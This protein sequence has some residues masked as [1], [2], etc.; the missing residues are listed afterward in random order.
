[1]MTWLECQEKMQWH[2][3]FINTKQQ[4]PLQHT[5]TWRIIGL[6]CTRA[7]SVKMAHHPLAKVVS[8][9]NLK[10]QY[11]APNFQDALANFVTRLNYPEA[12]G[13]TLRLRAMD[14]LIPF[15][16]VPVFHVVKFTETNE[17]EIIDSVHARPEQ[18][19]KHGQIIPSHFD[20]VLVESPNRDPKQGWIKGK[21]VFKIAQST[22]IDWYSG[23]QIAQVRTVFHLPMK[24]IPNFCPAL[25]TLSATPSHLAYVEWFSPLAASP[26]PKHLMYWVSRLTQY[27]EWR[28]GIIPVDWIHCSVHLLPCF[29]P[30][31]PPNWSSFTVLDQ[32]HTFYLN[33]FTDIHSF[34]AFCR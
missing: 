3:D 32:C 11:G 31:V 23:L 14:T 16:G 34:I 22:V 19:D 20:T 5:Q 25:D 4:G 17:S 6:P 12:R 28:A 27:G 18:R 2:A 13:S 8:F 21:F 24:S 26:D 33:P 15:R 10:S 1:M 29:G 7:Q 9:D 30:V